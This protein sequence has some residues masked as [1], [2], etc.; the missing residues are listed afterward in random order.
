[1]SKAQE[2]MPGPVFVELPIDVLYPYA[3]TAEEIVGGNSGGKLTLQKRI[4]DFYMNCYL[5]N[6][7]TKAFDDTDTNVSRNTPPINDADVEKV[8]SMLLSA[9]RP[10]IVLQSQEPFIFFVCNLSIPGRCYLFCKLDKGN[11]TAGKA[12]RFGNLS[13]KTWCSCFPGWYGSWTIRGNFKGAMSTFSWSRSKK[14]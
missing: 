13:R 10:V 2:G 3:M 14:I 6:L 1:M 5:H 9:E 8:K 11:F 4:V 12:S 7:F